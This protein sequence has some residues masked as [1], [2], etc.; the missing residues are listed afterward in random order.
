MGLDAHAPRNNACFTTFIAYLSSS[1]DNNDFFKCAEYNPACKMLYLFFPTFPASVVGFF[2]Q[3]GSYKIPQAVYTNI[4]RQAQKPYIQRDCVTLVSTLNPCPVGAIVGSQQ[5]RRF[6]SG[7]AEPFSHF[8]SCVVSRR[9][10]S[11]DTTFF[12]I[13]NLRRVLRDPFWTHRG[14]SDNR[15]WSH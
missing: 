1:D 8:V 2:R 15:A 3:C 11:G 12:S 14:C 6:E 5:G 7:R 4:F 10:E 9:F 13:L